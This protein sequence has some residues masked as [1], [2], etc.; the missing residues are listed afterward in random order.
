MQ[1]SYRKVC[2]LVL[3]LGS[4]LR[5]IGVPGDGESGL[6][7]PEGHSHQGQTEAALSSHGP[8]THSH[9]EVSGLKLC[10]DISYGHQI[11]EQALLLV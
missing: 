3:A 5:A 6:D 7:S 1:Y 11:W 4:S 2:S 9:R 8:D 10:V